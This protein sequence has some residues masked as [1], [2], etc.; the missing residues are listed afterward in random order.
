LQDIIK[1]ILNMRSVFIIIILF[2][3][4]ALAMTFN[5]THICFL[6]EE[7]NITE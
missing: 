6:K 2:L 3:S 4:N 1:T 5:L 7:R